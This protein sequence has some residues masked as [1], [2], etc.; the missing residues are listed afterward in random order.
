MSVA[1]MV[2]QLMSFVFLMLFMWIG[3]TYVS[4]N[5]Q[6]S[7]AKQFYN[8]AVEQIENSD[9]RADIIQNCKEKAIKKG[10]QLTVDT[11]GEEIHTDARVVL[12]FEFIYPVI[13]VGKHYSIEGYAR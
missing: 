11:Y 2:S 13:Q 9:F 1:N 12:D 4:Q 6:Y 10:Y 3:V 8:S 7:C 5:I